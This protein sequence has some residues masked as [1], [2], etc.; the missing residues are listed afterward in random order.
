MT[1]AAGVL[2]ASLLIGG[3]VRAAPADNFSP[4]TLSMLQS[5]TGLN[6]EQWNNIM[7]LINKPEQDDPNWTKFY[8]YCENIGDNR[9]YT[10][11]IFGATTGGSNDT[12]PDGPALFKE[13]DRVSGASSPSTLGGTARVGLH[14]KLSNGILTFSDSNSTVVSKIHALQNNANWRTAMWNTFYNVYIGYSVT[15]AHNRGFTS[16]LT[17]G[18]FVDCALNQGAQ[19]DA[20]ALSGML[21]QTG[22]ISDEKAFLTK[23]YQVRTKVVDTHDF[24]QAPNG[25]NRVKQWSTLLSKGETDLKNCDALIKSVTSW[26]LQ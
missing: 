13:Y 1:K 26:T 25:K 23:F 17:I 15:Q 12:G 3:F 6:A 9:G 18:S 19:G 5:K 20:N 8:G 11:G 4:A 2:A 22:S 7:I 24:N 10:I 21:S 16:A 14:G